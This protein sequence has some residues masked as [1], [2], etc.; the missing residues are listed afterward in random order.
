MVDDPETC[1]QCGFDSADWNDLDTIRTIASAPKL[2]ELWTDGMSNEHRDRRRAPGTW[3]VNEYVDHLRETFFGLRALAAIALESPGTGLGPVIEPSP[4]GSHRQVDVEQV[5]SAIDVEA[6]AFASLLDETPTETWQA[7][8]VL[9]DNRRSVRWASRH[10]VHDLWHHLIDISDIRRT[11]EDTAPTQHGSLV[12]INVYDGGVPKHSVD[13]ASIGRRG[14]DGDT[15]N[16]RKHHGRPWQALCLWSRDV[17][18][19]LQAEGH[20]ITAGSAGE[21]LTLE[22]IDWS[23]LRAGS[24][25]E[26]GEVRCQLSAPAIP[27]AKNN[28][29]F[30]DGDSTRILHDRHPGWGRWY[31]SVIITGTVAPNDPVTVS[32]SDHRTLY[33]RRPESQCVASAQ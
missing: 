22:G 6:T 9:G 13:Q 20:P 32:L 30:A 5:M 27:C 24:I 14:I 31:A 26:I 15:Q 33:P 29:W 21:N 10:V 12:Q 28:R 17:I 25:L 2:L 18:T 7:H 1:D 19:A 23:T 3:S 11:L 4:A 16:A 8:V